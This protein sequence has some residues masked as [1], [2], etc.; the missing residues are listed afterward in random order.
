METMLLG[1]PDL[2]ERLEGEGKPPII[3]DLLQEVGP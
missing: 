3:L 2:I 1:F